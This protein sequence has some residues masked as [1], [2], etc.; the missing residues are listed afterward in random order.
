MRPCFMSLECGRLI[1][2]NQ[3]CSQLAQIRASK[4]KLEQIR[5]TIMRAPT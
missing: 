1:R 3:H 2:T 5:Y 4:R